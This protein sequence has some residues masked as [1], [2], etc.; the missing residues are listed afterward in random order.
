MNLLNKLWRDESGMILSAETVL[1]G[2]I[3]VIGVSAGLHAVGKAVNKELTDVAFAVRSLDQSYS[4]PGISK[5]GA[6][7]AGSTFQQQPVAEVLRDLCQEIDRFEKTNEARPDGAKPSP[8]SEAPQ[9]QP[10]NRTHE[11]QPQAPE[12]QPR[13]KGQRRR[14]ED[15]NRRQ[16][17]NERREGKGFVDDEDDLDIKDSI[18]MPGSVPMKPLV[19]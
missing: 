15:Q 10:R 6:K 17:D 4:Y 12:T 2:T 13:H 1:V 7:T 9:T 14:W 19:I 16:G 11:T 18:P 8:P 5:C 3:G